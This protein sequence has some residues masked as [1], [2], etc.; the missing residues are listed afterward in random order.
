[1]NF[2]KEDFVSLMIGFLRKPYN[3]ILLD[4]YFCKLVRLSLKRVS[5][6]ETEFFAPYFCLSS[7]LDS[8]SFS[9]LSNRAGTLTKPVWTHNSSPLYTKGITER[10]KSS[11]SRKMKRH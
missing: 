4:L 8:I 7:K 9:I 11:F 5:G 1:M 2:L 6:R 3:L 10:P